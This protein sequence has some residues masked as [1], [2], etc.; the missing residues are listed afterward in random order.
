MIYNQ[1]LNFHFITLI[2]LLD[3]F[4]LQN[5]VD[6]D[7]DES[8]QEQE[9]VE[10][11]P[12]TNNPTALDPELSYVDD[13]SQNE[14]SIVQPVNPISGAS[15][16]GDNARTDDP[17]QAQGSNSDTDYTQKLKGN[18]DTNSKLPNQGWI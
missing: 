1:Y 6:N 11:V 10:A 2:S 17:F 13:Q 5:Q 7:E 8:D 9:T 15:G 4:S 14:S 18:Q 16:D 3:L 12:Y